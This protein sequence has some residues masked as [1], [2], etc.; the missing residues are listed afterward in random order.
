LLNWA[1]EVVRRYPGRFFGIV[2]PD[3][4]SIMACLRTIERAVKE[5]GFEAVKAVKIEP[6][7]LPQPASAAC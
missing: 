2:S 1:T 7:V 3:P 5:H 6:F 4:T